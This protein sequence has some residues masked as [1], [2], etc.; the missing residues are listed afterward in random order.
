MVYLLLP[1]IA[2]A[3][4]LAALIVTIRLL[5]RANGVGPWWFLVVTLA[6]FAAA[7]TGAAAPDR[8]VRPVHRTNARAALPGRRTPGSVAGAGRLAPGRA[9]AGD[10][11]SLGHDR[12]EG[13]VGVSRVP[14]GRLPELRCGRVLLADAEAVAD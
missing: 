14:Q 12:P 8:L 10:D 1:L 2:P 7:A 4:Y 5:G 13:H 9:D 3:A 11:A 6:G